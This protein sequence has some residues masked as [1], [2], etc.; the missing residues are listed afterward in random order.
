MFGNVSG[1]GFQWNVDPVTDWTVFNPSKD[2]VIIYVSGR[3]GTPGTAGSSSDTYDGLSPSWTSGTHGPKLTQD[4]AKTA[5]NSRPFMPDWILYER[6]FTYIGGLLSTSSSTS[7][8]GGRSEKEPFLFSSYGSGSRPKFI[9]GPS[10][11]TTDFLF[12]NSISLNGQHIAVV[13]L[14]F[15]DDRFDLLSPNFLGGTLAGD[16]T[17]GSN[18]IQNIGS[19]PSN[20]ANGMR[21]D[22]P[23]LI[24]YTITAIGANSVTLNQNSTASGTQVNIQYVTKNTGNSI[25]L[26]GALN[27]AYF[28]DCNFQFCSF[29]A[30]QNP[31]ITSPPKIRIVFRRCTFERTNN[32]NAGGM[33]FLSPLYPGNSQTLF[34][35]NL[36]RYGGWNPDLWASGASVFTHNMYLHDPCGPQTI[37]QNIISYGSATGLQLRDGGEVSNN[38]WLSQ[39]TVIAMKAPTRNSTFHDNVC[40]NGGDLIAGIRTAAAAAS[41]GTTLTFDGMNLSSGVGVSNLSNPGSVKGNPGGTV[42]GNTVTLTGTGAGIFAGVRGNG[43]QIGDRL[44]FWSPRTFG[45]D[46]VMGGLFYVMPGPDNSAGGDAGRYPVGTTQFMFGNSNQPNWPATPL[47]G[48][49]TVGTTVY[50]G[51]GNTTAPTLWSPNNTTVT[52]ISA[53]RYTVTVAAATINFFSTTSNQ[54]GLWFGL[55]TAASSNNFRPRVGPNNIFAHGKPNSTNGANALTV[56]TQGDGIDISGNYILNW[57]PASTTNNIADNSVFANT[58]KTQNLNAIDLTTY[59]TASV[60]Y[61]D[62]TLRAAPFTGTI[63]AN[64]T[65][66]GTLTCPNGAVSVGDILFDNTGGNAVPMYTKVVSGSG[67]TFAV[68]MDFGP[69]RT[70]G[71]S[72]TTIGPVQMVAGSVDHFLT[73][74]LTVWNKDTYD[75]RYSAAVA[76][77]FIRQ[78]MGIAPI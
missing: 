22:G 5:L 42:S 72:F 12:Y 27:F 52:A 35:K 40:L 20:I 49:I 34:E 41:S 17:N 65:G 53:D 2:T 47:P 57:D 59:P 9:K 68:A 63:V 16:V 28:E 21:V 75:S 67:T 54:G 18:V 61:Y 77:N 50:P 74:A 31:A 7:N 46:V 23:G 4:A 64:G 1:V 48:W 3:G 62:A 15:Y 19:M 36:L 38:L 56:E 69:T 58:T 29:S 24:S 32:F 33:F 60:E 51:Y 10:S 78:R 43:V 13:G 76:N 14:D 73:Q 37:S 70:M 55:G 39:P 71:N 44:L 26:N 25:G 30:G 45:P 6:G 66:G 8:A 11:N